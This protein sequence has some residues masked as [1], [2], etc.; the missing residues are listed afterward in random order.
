[1]PFSQPKKNNLYIDIISCSDVIKSK[2][3]YTYQI[4][5]IGTIKDIYLV[6]NHEPNYLP[7]ICIEKQKRSSV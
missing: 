5:D 4:T 1:M 3:Q 6:W 7:N 2:L